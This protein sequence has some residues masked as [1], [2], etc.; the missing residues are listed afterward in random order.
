MKI[1][2]LPLHRLI[3]LVSVQMGLTVPE[4]WGKPAESDR[5][6]SILE[7]SGKQRLNE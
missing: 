4:V 3:L 1:F 5:Q 7:T 2:C 6:S